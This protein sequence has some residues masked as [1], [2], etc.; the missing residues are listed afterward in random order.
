MVLIENGITTMNINSKKGDYFKYEGVELI[1]RKLKIYS[2]GFYVTKVKPTTLTRTFPI[3]TSDGMEYCGYFLNKE[4][5]I[6]YQ[7]LLRED[8]INSILSIRD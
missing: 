1:N 3:E 2:G 8:K 5:E 4:Q 7:Q 6:E